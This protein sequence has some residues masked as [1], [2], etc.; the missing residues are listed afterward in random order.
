M[1]ASESPQVKS[2]QKSV[3]LSNL[4]MVN[5]VFSVFSLIPKMFFFHLFKNLFSQGLLE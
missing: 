2:P 5:C 1:S 4:Q 3:E